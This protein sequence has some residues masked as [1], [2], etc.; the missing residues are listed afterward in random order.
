ME[1]FGFGSEGGVGHGSADDAA[2]E[3]DGFGEDTST[4]FCGDL[5]AEPLRYHLGG[6]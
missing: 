5:C 3:G 4:G 6:L 1:A 2:K